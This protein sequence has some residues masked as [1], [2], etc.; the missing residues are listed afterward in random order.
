MAERLFLTLQGDRGPGP[1]TGTPAHSHRTLAVPPD[2]RS[3]VGRAITYSETLPACSSI[4]ERVLPDG[5]L[6][7]T[8]DLS[9]SA[10][11]PVV[12]GPRIEAEA[13]LLH[14][15]M[16]GLSIEIHPAAAQAVLGIQVAETAGRAF[17]LTD[18]WG[19]TAEEL[20]DRLTEAMTENA[21][22]KI[23]WTTL[24]QRMAGLGPDRQAATLAGLFATGAT[25]QAVA[26]C[27]GIGNRR[28]Q[29]LCRAH[30]GLDP[31]SLRRL[32]RW[33]A[34]LRSL[35]PVTRPD[36]ADLAIAHGWSD[37]AHMVRDFR[38]FSG[39]TPTQ[40]FAA[41]SHSF[42]TNCPQDR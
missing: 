7:L 30:L 18:L 38:A 33:H 6:R 2:L 40:Y 21:R 10:P 23:L 1:E 17:S 42:K 27:L 22:A 11:L 3:V 36:W 14:G 19:R 16:D 26:E 35:R 8:L 37:Q 28:L 4:S 25:P 9:G 15:R 13:V 34:L 32:A 20:G 29:Q 31:R 24:R 5:L 39:L 12:I 41:V